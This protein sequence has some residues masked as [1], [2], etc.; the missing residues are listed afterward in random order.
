MVTPSPRAMS[1]TG[2]QCG[3]ASGGAGGETLGRIEVETRVRHRVWLSACLSTAWSPIHGRSAC[4]AR[5][6]AV[7]AEPAELR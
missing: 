6:S 4:A 1:L 5:G 2:I 3:R 7:T